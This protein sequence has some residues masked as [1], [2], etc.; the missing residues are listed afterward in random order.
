MTALETRSQASAALAQPRPR[1][2]RQTRLQE[3]LRTVKPGSRS[4]SPAGKKPVSS[5]SSSASKTLPRSL[6]SAAA[7]S[8][9]RSEAVA[10]E[11]P[12]SSGRPKRRAAAKVVMQ[13][14]ELSSSDEDDED[15]AADPADDVAE[16]APKA[17]KRS[18]VRSKKRASVESEDDEL[19][20][21]LTPNG[22]TTGRKSPVR[23]QSSP[24]APASTPS[25]K[26]VREPS[27][28]GLNVGAMNAAEV[29][30]R[31]AYEK[32][33]LMA[34][35]A[36][37]GIVPQPDILD[38]ALDRM[39]RSN[40]QFTVE[41]FLR[42]L[43]TLNTNAS[44]VQR[45]TLPHLTV[46]V[47][48]PAKKVT[49]STLELPSTPSST[50]GSLYQSP[51]PPKP[52][53]ASQPVAPPMHLL[54]SPPPFGTDARARPPPSALHATRMASFPSRSHSMPSLPTLNTT[55]P[56][57]PLTASS[58][59]TAA[60]GAVPGLVATSVA[61][62]G[63]VALSRRNMF[64]SLGPDSMQQALSSPVDAPSPARPS[65]PP[66]TPTELSTPQSNL[67]P[68][69]GFSA[70][71][72][73]EK[74]ADAR[75]SLARNVSSAASLTNRMS[76]LQSW[77]AEDDDPSSDEDED[78]RGAGGSV[79]AEAML[80]A[81][82]AS[83]AASSPIKPSFDT[84]MQL[85]DAPASDDERE[86]R[87]Q[88]GLGGKSVQVLRQ[89]HHR[90]QLEQQQLH[91]QSRQAKQQA[92]VEDPQQGMT[93]RASTRAA[94]KGKGKAL[95][96]CICGKD[97][98]GH[99]AAARCSECDVAFHLAC[100][101]VVSAALL[102]DAWTCVRC[103]DVVTDDAQD[104][105]PVEPNV[106]TT[107]RI[108]NKRVRIGTNSTPHIY[109]EPTFVAS[110]PVSA[111]RGNNFSHCADM[112][113][114]P[115]PTQSPIRRFASTTIAPPTSPIPSASKL[116]IPV[117][118]KF[119]E[120]T[121]RAPGDYS[122]TSPQNYRTRAGRTRMVSGGAF[123]G[124]EWMNAWDGQAYP[125]DS[126]APSAV[127][128]SGS[129]GL[130]AL[131]DDEWQLPSWSDVTMTPSRALSSSTPGSAASSAVWD[132]PFARSSHARR[133]SN[134]FA[135]VTTP[136]HLRTPSQDFLAA[137]DRDAAASMQQ[138]SA[139]SHVFA[140]RL[141]GS[142]SPS[143]HPSSALFDPQQHQH[144]AFSSHGGRPPSPLNPRRNLPHSQS[145]H[146]AAHPHGHQRKVSLGDGLA[147]PWHSTDLA[148]SAMKATQSAPGGR[149]PPPQ[150][151]HHH[152]APAAS[153]HAP[154]YHHQP[155]QHPAL[156]E[157]Q[158]LDDLLV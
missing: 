129:G 126:A 100:L 11:Q 3:H 136:H 12:S 64:S 122:P 16:E 140:Q 95:V 120:A 103:A 69:F 65:V 112:A 156:V 127:A 44:P 42:T 150:I 101:S 41:A 149:L 28:L 50:A 91:Q 143:S 25:K 70:G 72:S 137:L 33:E 148:S 102:P 155:A 43:S 142:D 134:G 139:P 39:S 1:R 123:L 17:S 98:E 13:E 125:D 53:V 154:L 104:V 37:H 74:R 10:A 31:L 90:Q 54:P 19:A 51:P 146:G 32:T 58:P 4:S 138:H 88:G 83:S 128:A 79:A 109:Q 55:L 116:P 84:E 108:Q 15:E 24:S 14:A 80:K 87:V 78:K 75:P 2:E 45:P 81:K 29:Q 144:H 27:D 23:H 60:P 71:P 105:N 30:H 20:P 121:I 49:F 67:L 77:L 63:R 114:A 66:M 57:P 46:S 94:A 62:M 118:P 96:E 18:P 82:V 89:S 73:P 133:P 56:T 7:P 111:P 110:T 85:V 93:T 68:A 38:R 145:F 131:V 61:G 59:T 119:G 124:S 97:A 130:S 152:V 99:H 135:P 48:P 8:A 141:F 106:Q 35:L 36:Q 151:Q 158:M 22:R 113:L 6:A 5:G 153:M 52:A 117:T 26:R 147:N 92:A 132:T 86:P 107:P 34:R 9:R 76:K 157:Q 115:S 21:S 40:V 47:P